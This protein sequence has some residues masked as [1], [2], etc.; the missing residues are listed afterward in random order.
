MRLF[1]Q[2]RRSLPA[3]RLLPAVL[4]GGLL[5]LLAACDGP[6]PAISEPDQ[7]PNAQ[8]YMPFLTNSGYLVR[9]QA[10]STITIELPDCN[11]PPVTGCDTSY[12]RTAVQNGINVWGDVLAQRGITLNIQ[13]PAVSNHIKVLWEDGSVIPGVLGYAM[14]DT[15]ATPSRR[16]VITT[17]CVVCSPLINSA[18]LITT[19]TVHEMGH[20]LG[21]WSH[22]FDYA[23]IMYPVDTG[24]TTRSARDI[25]TMG[26][27]YGFTPD[28]DLTTLGFNFAA[29]ATGLGGVALHETFSADPALSSLHTTMPAD[30]PPLHPELQ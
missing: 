2:H 20:M 6:L 24:R 10:G 5:L 1:S 30:P 16:F 25:A 18:A 13:S 19:I 4:L 8:D 17:R 9:W 28:L 12:M 15:S 11:A 23:D 27:L 29:G 26:Y 3:P 7:T 21:I 22:S 14:I